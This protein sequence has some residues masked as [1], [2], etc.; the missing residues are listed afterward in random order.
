MLP[1]GWKSR[2]RIFFGRRVLSSSVHSITS[3]MVL[4]WF[5]NESAYKR[6]GSVPQPARE[7]LGGEPE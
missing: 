4:A 5:A 7:G 6:I 3:K 1:K 2:L